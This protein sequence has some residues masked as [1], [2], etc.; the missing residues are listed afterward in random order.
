MFQRTHLEDQIT[1]TGS[2]VN[3]AVPIVLGLGE[4]VV[5]HGDDCLGGLLDRGLVA[6]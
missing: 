4:L 1:A 5:L 3:T 2:R 6:C